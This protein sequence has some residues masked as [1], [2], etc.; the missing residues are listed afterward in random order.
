[1]KVVM[2]R[3]EQGARKLLELASEIPADQWNWRPKEG[4]RTCAEVLRHVA[5][6]NEYLAASLSSRAADDSAN[7]ISPGKYAAKNSILNALGSSA[8]QVSTA[9][10]ALGERIEP[11]HTEQVLQ[12]IEHNSEHYGQLA[13]YARMLGVVPPASRG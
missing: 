11:K 9:L 3:W 8:E 6:W 10:R 13:V 1:M 7:E 12:F 2:E 4:T 5:F